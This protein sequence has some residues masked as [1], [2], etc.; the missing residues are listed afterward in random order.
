MQYNWRRAWG[1][2]WSLESTNRDCWE[3]WASTRQVITKE[4]SE[5]RV[6]L[7]GPGPAADPI[8]PEGRCEDER[9]YE[10]RSP[11][12]SELL[13]F[14][15]KQ[16]GP[17]SNCSWV[18]LW[19]LLGASS[20]TPWAVPEPRPAPRKDHVCNLSGVKPTHNVPPCKCC[21]NLGQRRPVQ[22]SEREGCSALCP[23]HREPWQ[24][25]AVPEVPPDHR[26]HRVA[27]H[28]EVSGS[29]HAGALIAPFPLPWIVS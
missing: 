11:I 22:R 20:Q 16:S 23:L 25:C 7:G 4:G 24:A 18:S 5:M 8:W 19:K 1:E 17:W 26:P 2:H 27:V 6:H 10:A 14:K 3:T 13:S 12:S 29:G 21:I 28:K 9:A 15:P